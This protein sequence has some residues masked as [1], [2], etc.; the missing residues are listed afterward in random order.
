MIIICRC[1][2]DHDND[3]KVLHRCRNT[4]Y[5]DCMPFLYENVLDFKSFSKNRYQKVIQHL[6]QTSTVNAQFLY[7]YMF[8]HNQG[9]EYIIMAH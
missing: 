2:N 1:R 7:S 4:V 9:H 6:W 3:Y 5:M 8:L